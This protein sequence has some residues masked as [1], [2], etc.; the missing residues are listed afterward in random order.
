MDK[1]FRLE[2]PESVYIRDIHPHTKKHRQKEVLEAKDLSCITLIFD[3]RMEI[4]Y[5][6]IRDN[7]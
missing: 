7:D 2:I 1:I 6:E 3:E 4:Y 5:G